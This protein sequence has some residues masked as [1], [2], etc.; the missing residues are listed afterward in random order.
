MCAPP[1]VSRRRTLTSPDTRPE[2][3]TPGGVKG[4]MEILQDGQR[5]M[6]LSRWTS[7]LQWMESWRR[8][9]SEEHTSELQ[10]R[11]YLHS[12]PT[13]RSSDLRCFKRN[14]APCAHPLPYRGG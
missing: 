13:L 1:T 14:A 11:R 10:S 5:K 2:V 3:A 4:W 8:W 12:F 6:R 9:R 7:I